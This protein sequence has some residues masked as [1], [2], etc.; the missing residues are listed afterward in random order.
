LQATPGQYRN[1]AEKVGW[2]KK[3]SWLPYPEL[4]FDIDAPKGHLPAAPFYAEEIG[5]GWAAT[6]VEKLRC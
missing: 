4:R 5:T 3:M 2:A 1:F 6:L